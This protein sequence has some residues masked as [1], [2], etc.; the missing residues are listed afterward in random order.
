MKTGYTARI[1]LIALLHDAGE[2]Y[3]SDIPS[4]IKKFIPELSTIEDNILRTIFN[5]FKIEY[6]SEA[7]WEIVKEI[8]TAILSAEG[9]HLTHNVE[10]WTERY[11][12][13]KSLLFNKEDFEYRDR[14]EVRKEF[15]KHFADLQEGGRV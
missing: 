15:I 14:L 7:E 5:S 2:A 12:S 11:N 4:P 13:E 10:N 3:L 8:D 6:P 1:A 9:V